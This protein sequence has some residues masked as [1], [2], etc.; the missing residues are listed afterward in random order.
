MAGA[1]RPGA[2][3]LPPLDDEVVDRYLA[4]LGLEREPPSVDALHRL[5]A[6]H[7][8]RIPYETLWIAEG[9]LWPIDPLLSA[10]RVATTSRGG[11]CLHLN[12]ALAALLSSLGYAMTLHVGG[13]HGPD[14]PS[15]D[16]LTNHMALVVSGLP[17]DDW[18]DGRWYA[19]AGLGDALHR[20]LPLTPTTVTQGPF[21][22]TLDRVSGTGGVGD[23]HLEHDPA[24]A[25]TGMSFLA[26]PT[27][28]DAFADRHHLMSTSPESGFV[29][30]LTAQRRDAD[31]V[32]IV[33]NLVHTRLTAR[34][35]ETTDLVRRDDWAAVLGDVFGLVPTRDTDALWARI[36]RAHEEWAAAGRP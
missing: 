21:T 9:D 28:V 10:A 16:E 24:G 31:S 19:D 2:V 4:R 7:V 5:H 11:Y 22:M 26:G 6:R 30:V 32:D 8:E 15:A 29:R 33:R 12:G 25:F 17:T 36:S 34:G 23:W 20:P 13:V 27:D 1:G 3:A 35:R 14:G 18:A